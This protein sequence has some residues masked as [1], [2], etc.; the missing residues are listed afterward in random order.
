LFR[1]GKRVMAENVRP[2]EFLFLMIVSLLVLLGIF[3]RFKGLGANCLATDEYYIA[4]S[5]QSI[6]DG[7]LPRFWSGGYYMRG[8]AMQ[9][10]IAPFF[11]LFEGH[12]EFLVRIFP[13][14]FNIAGIFLV[15]KL[16]VL[17]DDRYLGL[18]AAALF[19]VSLWE[20]EMARFGRMY[21]PFQTLF[22]W[23][24]LF[25]IKAVF[26]PEKK[27][28]KP[29]FLISGISIFIYEGSVFLVLM[30]FIPLLF[31]RKIEKSFLVNFFCSVFLFLFN[32]V[33][34]KVDFRRLGEPYP[35]P[36]PEV[37]GRFPELSSS[38]VF[39]DIIL[40]KLVEDGYF[41]VVGLLVALFI[42]ESFLVLKD[43]D[44]YGKLKENAFFIF[45]FFISAFNLLAL[46]LSVFAGAVCL[47]IVKREALRSPEIK[48][49]LG[50]SAL[51]YFL[52]GVFWFLFLLNPPGKWIDLPKYLLGFPDFW[53]S[54]FRP[55]IS[56]APV[57]L[58]LCAI[59]V[60]FVFCQSSSR[61]DGKGEIRKFLL[62]ILFFSLVVLGLIN[63]VLLRTRYSFFL[64]PL[65]LLFFLFA[66]RRVLLGSG[67]HVKKWDP[68]PFVFAS[69]LLFSFSEDFN[70][71]HFWNVDSPVYNFRVPYDQD[72]T[73]HFYGRLE[74]RWAAQVVDQN[75]QEDDLIVSADVPIDFY[76]K[77]KLDYVFGEGF[78][79]LDFSASGGK[80]D[81]WT[82][83]EILWGQ[84]YFLDLMKSRV[85]DIWFVIN[86]RYLLEEKID[87]DPILRVQKK[88][89]RIK[90]PFSTLSVYRIVDKT[91]VF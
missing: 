44:F 47:G 48:K 56:S 2:R 21:A 45:L 23:Y 57:T 68:I 81:R 53:N 73:S 77:N 65:A 76:L 58:G 4:K 88:I 31:Y 33:Y 62:G 41:L 38:L 91:N 3:S 59:G 12:Y 15:F 71:R 84:Q 37:M 10:A 50:F 9:Y 79:L 66:V 69:F 5:V 16:G 13:V 14:L 7:G 89:E 86:N 24:L 74:F 20:I 67:S 83:A 49:I 19:S 63:V 1:S 46:Q 11:V 29:L 39:P 30:N 27:F 82:K 35:F 42:V 43:L 36:P 60:I 28:L 6:A 75:A 54:F 64:Y 87:N 8:V 40:F 22:L 17:I 18:A 55:W 32:F 52:Y 34:F 85:C 61:A 78:R 70:F 90:S 72:L 80:F 25:L 26:N 51:N